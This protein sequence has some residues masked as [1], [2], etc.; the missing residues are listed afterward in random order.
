MNGFI[1]KTMAAAVLAAG[2]AGAGCCNYHDL[3]DPC[4]P[5][6]YNFAART[7]VCAAL[8]PQV[9]NG[10]VL[11]QTVWNWMFG[12]P[13][14]KGSDRLNAAGMAHLTTLART[15]PAP[16]PI[17]YLATAQDITY[18]PEAPEGAFADARRELDSKRIGAIQKYLTAQTADRGL[19]FQVAVHDPAEP[20]LPARATHNAIIT[21]YPAFIGSASG[22]T[23]G[24]GGGGGATGR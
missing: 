18:N 12:D 24:G 11:E 5:Q 6:R 16:D 4:Y 1:G 2:L 19:A 15:R 17:I 22:S 3:V 10:H 21:W 20:D 23:G 7:E 14:Q 13:G 9:K 8:T